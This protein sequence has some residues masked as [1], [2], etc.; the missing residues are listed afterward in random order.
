MGFF[1]AVIAAIVLE[2]TGVIVEQLARLS[3]IRSVNN[4]PQSHLVNAIRSLRSGV[5]LGYVA[6]VF[7]SFVNL[8]TLQFT[9]TLLLGD[10]NVVDIA[11]GTNR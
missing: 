8:V 6:V 9:S 11:L 1:A 10:F 2:T 3:V 4:G 5:Q 7:I